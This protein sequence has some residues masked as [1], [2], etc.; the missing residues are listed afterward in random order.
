MSSVAEPELKL[1]P[2]SRCDP[3]IRNGRVAIVAYSHHA[4]AGFRFIQSLKEVIQGV[5]RRVLYMT[6]SDAGPARAPEA[7]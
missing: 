5:T 1:L 6:N 2:D 7:T 4:L 3:V